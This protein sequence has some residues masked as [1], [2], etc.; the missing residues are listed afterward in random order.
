M[1]YAYYLQCFFSY[2]HWRYSNETFIPYL[3]LSKSFAVS[4]SLNLMRILTFYHPL[5]TTNILDI[6]HS[7][8]IFYCD[9]ID[10][11]YISLRCSH[12]LK[13]LLHSRAF[14]SHDGSPFISMTIP[15][16]FP[17]SQYCRTSGHNFWIFPLFKSTPSYLW[18]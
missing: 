8:F 5:L 11:Q 16:S 17:V 3:L 6:N 12:L 4:T 13:L 15:F 18:L 14:H 7:H 9:I 10:I 2:S 1:V